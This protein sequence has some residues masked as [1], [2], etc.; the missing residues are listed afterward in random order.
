MEQRSIINPHCS[1]PKL[2]KDK[3]RWS[4]RFYY[5]LE[6]ET[7][8]RKKDYGL[9]GPDF[10][11]KD[12]G[13]IKAIN[14]SD[15]LLYA[16][17]LLKNEISRLNSMYFNPFTKEFESLDKSDQSFASLLGDYLDYSPNKVRRESTK[18]IYKSYNN[19][20]KGVL[21]GLGLQDSTLKEI[22]RS[23]VER[24]LA[25]IQSKSSKAQ[26]D[27]YLRYLKGFFA[28]CVDHLEI[29]SKSPIKT[30]KSINN[31]ETTTNKAYPP[32]ILQK[33]LNEA[34]RLDIHFH[35]LLRLLIITLRRPDELL[36]LQLK[37][38]DFKAGSV[39]F[40]KDMIKTNRAQITYLSGDLVAELQSMMDGKYNQTDYFLGH[41]VREVGGRTNKSIFA[42]MKTS[43]VHFQDKFKTIQKRLKLEKGY[44]IYSFK[45]TSIN[46][47]IDNHKWSKEKVIK[48]T[49]HTNI[50]ILDT[51][52]KDG[53][54]E[55]IEY[56]ENI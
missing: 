40:S 4:I 12:K 26:R 1:E 36:R 22:D 24:L 43:F 16:A 34:K 11:K 38:F 48:L 32:E 19:R 8:T 31:D 46:N 25:E 44:T 55:R 47:L 51:Y 27:H 35:L 3:L 9:N 6:G 20:I 52:T 7:K 23:V 2:L 17:E 13:I 53:K 14:K 49:G 54:R 41:A 33:V 28:Y 50:S 18:S 30:L 39:T 45:H 42:P 10:L 15:R 56:P 5:K 29:L 37:N 21:D